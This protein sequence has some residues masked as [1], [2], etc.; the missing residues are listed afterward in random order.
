MTELALILGISLLGIGFAGY[1]ARWVLGCPTGEGD[2][3]RVAARIRAAAVY[4]TNRLR[5]TIL[6]VSAVPGGGIFLAYGL[7]RQKPEVQAFP[8]LELGAWLTLSFSLGVGSAVAAAHVAAWTA[9]RANV[10]AA[11]GARRSLDHA[12]QIAIRGGAVSGLFSVSLGL[13]G[14]VGLFAAVFAQ[15]GGFSA[16]PG[17]ALRLA[18]SIPLVIAGYALGGAFAALIAELG[19]GAFAKSADMGADLAG[20]E[21]GLPEDDARNPATIA[22][23]AGDCAGEGAG[24]AASAFASTAAENLGAMLLA[25]AVFRQNE[26]IP[27]VLSIMLFPV[28]TRAFG[29]LAA[30]FGV[31]VV[32]TDDREDPMNAL[33]RGLFVTAL[34]GAVGTAGAAKWL[35]GKHWLPLFGAAAVG[36]AAGILLLFV[37][38]YYTE[39]R[40][41]PVREIAEAARV[42]PPLALLRGASVGLESA[43]APLVILGAAVASAHVLGA[44][45][46]LDGGGALGIAVAT[47]GLL[48]TSAYALAMA[49]FAPII[50]SA[51]GIVE[52]TIGRER[53][54][55]RGRTVV[56][57]AVGN[58]AKAFTRA[59][60]GA[61][62]L[63]ATSML[64]SVWLDEAKR[65]LP[66]GK[67][68][69]AAATAL[70]VGR[71][72]VY[73]GAAVGIVLVVWFASRCIGGVSRAA[74]RILEEARRQINAPS[75]LG[76]STAWTPPHPRASRPSQ[77]SAPATRAGLGAPD[78]DACVELG[79]RA[80]LGHAITPALVAASVPIAVGLGL[81]FAGTE[82][83]PLAVADAV[84]ALILAATIAGVLGALLLG[85]AGGAWDN[86]KKYIVTGA[87]G[88]RYLV[89]ETGARVDNPTYLAAAFG[90][91]V[92]DPLKDAAGPA[93]HVLVKMLPVV[94]LVFLPFFV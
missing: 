60:T 58:T 89:D 75:S 35:L 54:D 13:I 62:A 41:R 37:A 90:D 79:S 43:L 81:R 30:M 74:R 1:L 77:S 32:R 8:P 50:D 69:A 48:G 68:A 94:T 24:K 16:E 93:I 4:F 26:G 57:D 91:T 51:G 61:A 36:M 56:L 42:G 67:P 46:G 25:A 31:M 27:S 78:L 15:K 40:Y 55:V 80:A 71:P 63:L 23:L 49:G 6:A 66:A 14:L 18:P 17:N 65:R 29:V 76:T 53:P 21:L 44:R 88:G 45:T 82:D 47:M 72:E 20:R 5:G 52:M 10:R 84:A 83:N 9:T 39:H 70:Q 11:S 3:P 92:G 86:A 73:L 33:A 28:I 64:V 34:L 22:D 87:H 12:L 19:G 59:H 7:A 38:Q 2:M 85:N